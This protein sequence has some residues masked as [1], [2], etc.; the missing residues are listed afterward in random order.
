[1]SKLLWLK[2]HPMIGCQNPMIENLSTFGCQNLHDLGQHSMLKNLFS[3][4][5]QKPPWLKLYFPWLDVKASMIENPSHDWMSKLPWL[6]QF[7]PWLDVKASMI[8]I[9]HPMMFS[10]VCVSKCPQFTISPPDFPDPPPP[11]PLLLVLLCQICRPTP[12][13]PLWATCPS[14]HARENLAALLHHPLLRIQLTGK[15]VFRT[16][17]RRGGG[18]GNLSPKRFRNQ[19]NKDTIIMILLLF[20]ITTVYI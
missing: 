18:G 14:G 1:M 17:T 16:G 15:I 12:P 11:H 20:I 5:C 2:I 4:W 19:L 10:R 7:T 8:E 13:P 6:K 3:I 9:L